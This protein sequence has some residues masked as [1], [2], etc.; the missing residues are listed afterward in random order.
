MTGYPMQFAA[1]RRSLSWAG[2]TLALAFLVFL[3]VATAQVRT[4]PLAMPLTRVVPDV[5][6][7]D[8]DGRPKRF[9][10]D[11]VRGKVVAINFVYTACSSACPAMGQRFAQIQR[12]L[13]AR[14]GQDVFLITIST[15]PAKDTPAKLKA[16]AAPFQPASGWTLVTGEVAPV[17]QILKV[18]TGNSVG[19]GTHLPLIVLYNDRQTRWREVFGL[20]PLVQL[21]QALTSW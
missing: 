9:Y 11:L 13:G 4:V 15:D 2:T 14:L 5:A 10:T 19:Q 21:S 7:V 6:V 20:A 1:E 17:Q 18:L 12:Q 16:W 3:P 8:Q